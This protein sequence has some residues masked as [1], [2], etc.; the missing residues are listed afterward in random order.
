MGITAIPGSFVFTMIF[1]P[2]YGLI[3]PNL[4]FSTEYEGL[5]PRLWGNSVFYFTL[6]LLPS[7]SL[8]RDFVWK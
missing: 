6:L 3:A 1:L 5:V 7:V 8:V 4:G 2:L